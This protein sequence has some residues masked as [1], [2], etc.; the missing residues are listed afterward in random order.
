MAPKVTPQ[1][2]ANWLATLKSFDVYAIKFQGF[3]DSAQITDFN[4]GLSNRTFKLVGPAALAE[5][6]LMFPF[7]VEA[8]KPIIDWWKNYCDGVTDG[9]IVTI[10]PV[11][12]C[13]NVEPNGPTLSLFGVRPTAMSGF[14]VDKAAQ[15]ANE[16][17]I[18]FVAE[19]WKYV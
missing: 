1:V 3:E 19:D 10:T 16:L 5:M 11:K 8:C 15:T 7:D 13:P 17:S 18:R 2:Q 6:T 14:D 4:D 12:Y 9:E